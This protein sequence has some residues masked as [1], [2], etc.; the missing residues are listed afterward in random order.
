MISMFAKNFVSAMFVIAFFCS[1]LVEGKPAVSN[2]K[3]IIYN[4]LDKAP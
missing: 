3:F 2:G 4:L 1:L